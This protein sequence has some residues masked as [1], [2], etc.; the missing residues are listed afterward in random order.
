[1]IL[2]EP[3]PLLTEEPRMPGLDGEKMSS[4][5]GNTIL[6]REDPDT[7][8][9]QIRTMPTDPARVRRKDPGSPEKCPVW[10]L[11]QLYSDESTREWV[12]DGCTTAGIGCLECKQCVV[13]AVLEELAPMRERAQEYADDP[14]QVRAILS[15]GTETARDMARDTLDEVRREMGLGPR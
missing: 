15:K 14:G 13:D 4:S 6:L 9:Q 5:Y 11:H 10:P 1:V 8:R 3:E 7:V 12:W 2:P